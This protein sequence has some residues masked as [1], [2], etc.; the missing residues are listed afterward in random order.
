MSKKKKKKKEGY[1]HSFAISHAKSLQCLARELRETSLFNESKSDADLFQGKVVGIPILFGL[2]TEVALKAL[3]YQETN[4]V[5]PYIHDLLK[6]F[7]GLKEETQT[8]LEAAFK[9]LGRNTQARLMA[10][11]PRP[12]STIRYVLYEHR[13]VFLLWRYPF[14]S[15]PSC[16][17]QALDEVIST[18]IKIYDE[19]ALASYLSM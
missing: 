8:E 1:N 3:L 12:S 2:A 17:P 19:R 5:P 16:Y 15:V 7:N 10:E 6:L 11:F 9:E 18:I 4:E 14:K 13:E